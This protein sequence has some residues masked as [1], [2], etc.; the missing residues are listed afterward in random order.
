MEVY[1]L[2]KLPP[3]RYVKILRVIIKYIYQHWSGVRGKLFEIV[4]NRSKLFEIVRNCSKLFEIVRN[5]SK[6]FTRISKLQNF[7]EHVA[8]NVSLST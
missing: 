6:L 2:K 4:R 5:C 1:K 3:L 8:D 7:V